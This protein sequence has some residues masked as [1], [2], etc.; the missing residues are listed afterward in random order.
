MSLHRLIILLLF[1]TISVGCHRKKQVTKKEIISQRIEKKVSTWTRKTKENCTDKVN[2]RAEAIV[3][4][5]L[6][7][8]A[9]IGKDTLNKPIRPKKPEIKHIGDTIKVTPLFEPD[10]IA[11]DISKDKDTVIH[12]KKETK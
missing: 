6:I 3:D 9:F 11:A 8:N 1:M 2:S 12:D 7:A 5:I 4:S 10:T